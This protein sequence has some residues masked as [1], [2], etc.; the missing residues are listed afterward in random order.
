MIELWLCNVTCVK[1]RSKPGCLGSLRG[2]Q[3][4]ALYCRS[5]D[6]GVVILVSGYVAIA[7]V[8]LVACWWRHLVNERVPYLSDSERCSVYCLHRP[9]NGIARPW[10]SP[11]LMVNLA[12]TLRE[13]PKDLKD[14]LI[15]RLPEPL[16]LQRA[17][18]SHCKR[19]I[20][21]LVVVPWSCMTI[22]GIV[23]FFA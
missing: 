4:S 21:S 20:S 13:R 19:C 2:F 1:K 6:S 16:L 14:P 11:P 22:D 15:R 18:C 23:T 7:T 12:V 17:Q 10:L 3:Q 5:V 9:Y 8:V